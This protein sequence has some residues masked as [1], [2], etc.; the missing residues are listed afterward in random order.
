MR[1]TGPQVKQ[2]SDA[3][4]SAFP[5]R[6]ELA[7]MMHYELGMNLETIADGGGQASTVFK[8]I[9]YWAE[10]KGKV[11]DLWRAARRANPGNPALRAITFLGDETTGAPEEEVDKFVEAQLAL[12]WQLPT[13]SAHITDEQ[14]NLLTAQQ[15]QFRTA[16]G[17]KESP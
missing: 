9:T 1:L 11:V 12:R 14:V 4:L 16:K 5:T 3:L 15:R 7:Q 8:V 10:P 6:V 2:L 13:A 17:S